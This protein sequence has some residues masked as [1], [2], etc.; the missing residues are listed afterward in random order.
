MEF[1]LSQKWN[2]KAMMTRRPVFLRYTCVK[3][4]LHPETREACLSCNISDVYGD[5][6][7]D[8]VLIPVWDETA[9]VSLSHECS[10]A[11]GGAVTITLQ[12]RDCCSLKSASSW[13]RPHKF[14]FFLNDRSQDQSCSVIVIARQL[15]RFCIAFICTFAQRSRHSVRQPHVIV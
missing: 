13:A 5:V 2:K 14:K 10:C 4:K 8:S 7:L 3:G 9:G 15:W 12:E 11:A 6:Y 1:C